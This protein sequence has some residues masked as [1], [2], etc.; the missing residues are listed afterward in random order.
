MKKF[1]I[2]VMIAAISATSAMAV[3]NPYNND[4]GGVLERPNLEAVKDNFTAEEFAYAKKYN[5]DLFNE[6]VGPGSSNLIGFLVAK[7]K[8]EWIE[9]VLDRVNFKDNFTIINPAKNVYRLMTS[10]SH[11]T[12]FK[13]TSNNLYDHID[14]DFGSKSGIYTMRCQDN[15]YAAVC[16][17]NP[18]W[19]AEMGMH[20]DRTDQQMLNQIKDRV[21]VNYPDRNVVLVNQT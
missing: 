19:L 2:S 3:D 5:D 14:H 4:T 6:L 11:T 21:Q 18:G 15:D 17:V 10:N 8:T 13:K 7:H 9:N 20:T 12:V 16:G 1:I